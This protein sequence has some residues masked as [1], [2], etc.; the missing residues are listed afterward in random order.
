MVW[1]ELSQICTPPTPTL[2]NNNGTFLLTGV[3][4][5][6]HRHLMPSIPGITE[7]HPASFIKVS[8][9]QQGKDTPLEKAL[10][11]SHSE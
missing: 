7:G 3:G 11:T 1:G 9:A 4:V 2:F 8:P 5:L 6:H 10:G